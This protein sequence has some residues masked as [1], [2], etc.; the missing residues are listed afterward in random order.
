M[1][2]AIH[3]QLTDEQTPN[4]SFCR[5]PTLICREAD[6]GIVGVSLTTLH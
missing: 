5:R 3:L 1:R 6:T 2:F 4:T